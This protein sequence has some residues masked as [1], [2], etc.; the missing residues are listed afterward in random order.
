MSILF[1]VGLSFLHCLYAET[2]TAKQAFGKWMEWQHVYKPRSVKSAQNLISKNNLGNIKNACALAQEEYPGCEV[3]YDELLAQPRDVKPSVR[4]QQRLVRTMVRDMGKFYDRFLPRLERALA[5]DPRLNVEDDD[6]NIT[7]DY[8]TRFVSALFAPLNQ[9]T[10]DEYLFNLAGNLFFESFASP[11]HKDLVRMLNDKSHTSVNR[12]L[13]SIMWYYLVGD[14]W[15]HYNQASIDHV[16]AD[17]AKGK[18]L[19][20]IAGGTDVYQLLLSG[21]YTIDVIDPML[22]TQDD[23]LSEGWNFFV[24]PPSRDARVSVPTPQGDLYLSLIS[25]KKIGEF[26]ADLS[27]ESHQVLP[28]TVT[29]WGV[30]DAKAKRLGTLTFYRRFCE[31]DDFSYASDRTYFISFNEM[32]Y[33]TLGQDNGGWGI[34]PE[35]FNS[36]LRLHVKQLSRPVDKKILKNIQVADAQ[37][38]SYIFLG[39]VPT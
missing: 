11:H 14:G 4:L 10:A 13:Y 35:K 6:I 9:S 2:I 15:K 31:Q 34:H 26:E 33:L 38:F 23:Y 8:Y 28:K 5:K 12:C 18:R 27:D 30:F 20:Y 39:S 25:H 1:L 36:K 17:I 24:Q 7:V 21:I 19:V 22:P 29:V 16:K 37:P 32:Y 3:V